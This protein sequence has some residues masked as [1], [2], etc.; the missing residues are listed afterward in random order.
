MEL[1]K[2]TMAIATAFVMGLPFVGHGQDK[3]RSSESR[4]PERIAP[5][6]LLV[7]S[8]YVNHEEH[9]VT[10]RG[11][12]F[13]RAV[14]FCET[15]RMTVVSASDTEVVVRVP[16]GLPDGT[17]LFTVA[18]GNAEVER[19]AFH[20]PLY[21]PTQ[22]PQG[23]PGPAGPEG[24]AGP[25]GPQ[26]ETGPAG[27]EGPTGPA[28]PA[29]PAGPQ[30]VPGAAGP[31]GPMGPSG[32]TGP[33]GPA[34]PAGP[35]GPQGLPGV[36][37]YQVVDAAATAPFALSPGI[38]FTWLAICPAGKLPFGGGHESSGNAPSMNVV[39]S[40]PFFSATG[41]GWRTILRNNTNLQLSN[42]AVRVWVVCGTALP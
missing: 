15:E 28:G 13:G 5:A 29:G 17:Y 22:G 26:G 1:T 11:M 42:V 27:P 32:P 21:A 20:V 12:N 37:G 30:G 23:E 34:G 35:A 9:T 40:A 18:R 38:Q 39:T 8:A 14:V 19:G 31:A 4:L 10:L 6:Q 41:N 16:A 3:A 33:V 25:A 7:L 2:L 24:P 36:S